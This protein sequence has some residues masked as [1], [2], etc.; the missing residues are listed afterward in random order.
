MM[1]P[2]ISKAMLIILSFIFL[3]SCTLNRQI[4]ESLSQSHA[5]ENEKKELEKVDSTFE[6]EEPIARTR[7]QNVS[8]YYVLQDKEAEQ[9]KKLSASTSKSSVQLVKEISSLKKA[10]QVASKQKPYKSDEEPSSWAGGKSLLNGLLFNISFGSIIGIPLSFFFFY[11]AVK[12]GMAALK[13]QKDSEK[14]LGILGLAI[15]ILPLLALIIIIISFL[16]KH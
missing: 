13:S 10:V 14:I 4:F 8:S 5:S 1:K 9:S 6:E 15:T 11:W 16:P 7:Y 2:L 12:N 3:T